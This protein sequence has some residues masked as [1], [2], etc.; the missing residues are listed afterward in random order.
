M[1]AAAAHALDDG[2]ERHVDL[3]HVVDGHAG[4]LHRLGLR[5]GAR[6]AIEQIALFAVAV[7]KT[8]LHQA[9][10]D[11]IGHQPARVHHLLGF[12]AQRRTGLHRGAQHVARGDLRNAELFA[13]EL[14]LRAFAG[15]RCA[16]QDQTHLRVLRTI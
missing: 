7:L 14:G 16:Q 4:F 9:D 5:N 13:D 11:V 12:D 8:V 3:Q 2:V 6:E 10:N 15:A 1:H